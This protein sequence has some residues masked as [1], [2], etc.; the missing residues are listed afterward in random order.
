MFALT[1]PNLDYDASNHKCAERLACIVKISQTRPVWC[2]LLCFEYE[3]GEEISMLKLSVM[4]WSGKSVDTCIGEPTQP[5]TSHMSDLLFECT[6]CLKHHCVT[7]YAHVSQDK[8]CLPSKNLTDMQQWIYSFRWVTPR[9]A[10][11]SSTAFSIYG[12]T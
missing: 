6:A 7:D 3:L 12:G 4:D 8:A 11:E 9:A 10:K 1:G 5:V 2:E